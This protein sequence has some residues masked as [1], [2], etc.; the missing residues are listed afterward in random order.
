MLIQTDLNGSPH[1]FYSQSGPVFH[2]LSCHEANDFEY[3]LTLA[4]GVW[5]NSGTD[6][7]IVIIIHGDEAQ[8]EPLILHKSTIDSR[9]LLARG[10]EDTFRIHLPMSL[11]EIEYIRIWHDNSGRDP[12][13]FLSH[14]ILLDLQTGRKWTLF[15]NDWFALE[16]GDGKIN[17]ILTPVGSQEMQTFSYSLRSQGS[18]GFSD[19]HI[20]LSVVTKPPRSKFSRVQRASCCLCIL[21]SAML[22]NAL[23]YRTDKEPDPTL[24][25]G[26]LKFSWRQIMVGIESALIIT[27][28]NLMIMTFFK[29]SGEK[30]P[31]KVDVEKPKNSPAPFCDKLSTTSSGDIHDID[32]TLNEKRSYLDKNSQSQTDAKKKFM[33]PH[34]FIYVAWFLV[35]VTVSVCAVFTFFFSLQWGKDISNQ[36]LS[37]MFVSFTQDLFVLQPLKILLIM[38]FTAS[39]FR[40]NNETETVSYNSEEKLQSQIKSHGGNQSVKVEMPKEDDLRLARENSTKEAKMFSFLR[41]L[42]GYLLFL[43]LLIIVCY[44]SRSYHGYLMTMDLKDTLGNFSLVSSS[45]S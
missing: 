12:S 3:Q 42:L 36:W 1:L 19:G 20:W 17:R 40:D 16:K 7:R 9:T 37:S 44:G 32:V 15:C 28:V 35:L 23:F 25:I 8:S 43:F 41:E 26:P 4:T 5:K 2:L 6:A 34:F 21:L 29:R 14:A 27:P 33:L 22:A 31:N 24:Q 38:V 45:E 30:T 39:L 18:R 10:N 11:G 13:W